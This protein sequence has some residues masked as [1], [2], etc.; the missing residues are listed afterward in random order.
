MLQHYTD[1]PPHSVAAWYGPWN[2][3]LATLFP[4]NQGYVIIPQLAGVAEGLQSPVPD[5]SIAVAKMSKR[6]RRFRIV[7]VVKIRGSAYWESDEGK[8]GLMRLIR[9]H[10]GD[11]VQD[12]EEIKVYW[13]GAIGPHWRYGER[14]GEIQDPRPMI[15]WHDVIH[16]DASYDDLMRLVDLVALL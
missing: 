10:T 7:L 2:T 9:I 14:E 1:N 15:S 13:I 8:D 3:I 11:A 6:P 5:F 4:S 12:S 16:D